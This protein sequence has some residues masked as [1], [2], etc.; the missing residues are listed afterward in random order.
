MK[1]DNALKILKKYRQMVWPEVQKYL[2]DPEYPSQ[3]KIPKKYLPE[4][5]KY[6]RIVNDYPKRQG[7][8]LR[9]TLLLLSAGA[10]GI[11]IKKAI[12]LAAAMQL[13]EEWLLI[14]DDIEDKSDR[15]RGKKTLHKLYGDGL[16]INAGDSLTT[17][18]WKVILDN[19][20]VL[21]KEKTFAVM[22]EFYRTLLRTEHGQAVEMMWTDKQ[23]KINDADWYFVADGKTSYYTMALPLRLGAI[24]A[25]AK[26]DQLDKLTE[27]ALY[28][29][30]CFQLVDDILDIKT[31]KKEGKLT[32]PV[33][34]G[35]KY[36]QNLA[37]QLKDIAQRI[38]DNDLD[39]LR[40]EPYRKE[41]K[42]LIKFILERKS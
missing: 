5:G 21:G 14:H 16:A 24:A 8:Y 25:N 22:E 29:G 3:F 31:D 11:E 32:L 33:L 37:I 18:M 15:R 27:F 35:V 26:P 20:S 34:K 23:R 13:S 40:T 12:K 42:E 19:Q 2:K 4:I 17:I 36:S 38:F 9:P 7:K 41:L 10:M 39:F 6:W 1:T 30:R 28:L